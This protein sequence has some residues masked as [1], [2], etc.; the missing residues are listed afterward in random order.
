MDKLTV[1]PARAE[2]VNDLVLMGLRFFSQSPYASITS[3]DADSA[4]SSIDLMMDRG[5]VLVADHS[6]S[7]VGGICGA[8]APLWFN[9]SVLVATEIAWWVDQGR[10]GGVAGVRL[11]QA[12]E[13]WAAEQGAAFVSLSDLVVHDHS[14][15]GP[16][17]QKLGYTL[18]ERSHVKEL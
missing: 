13:A 10:R 15:I 5:V 8:L 12:F 11:L 7:V 4:R 9:Q 14:T 16:L 3:F 6:G 2:E 1:R 17:V 18:I